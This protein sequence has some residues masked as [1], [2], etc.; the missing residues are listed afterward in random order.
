[1]VKTVLYRLH[2][3][4]GL[5]AGLVLAIVG[6][7]GAMLSFEEEIV[8]ALNRD[9]LRA[10]PTANRTALPPPQL[11]AAL[12]ATHP[13]RK[14]ANLTVFADA[15]LTPRVTFTA[16]RNPQG[17]TARNRRGET[18]HL[19]PYTGELLGKPTL[20][21]Q[22][23]LRLIEQLH[24][25]L[26]AG[27]PG[28]LIVGACTLALIAMCVSGLYLRWPRSG[29]GNWRRWLLIDN[30]LRGRAFLWQLHAVLG[31]WVLLAYL[32]S[33]LSGLYFSTYTW[34]RTGLIGMVGATPPSREA[35]RLP[36]A[37]PTDSAPLD[38]SALW[39]TFEQ[40]SG[41][42]SM[43]VL[44]LPQTPAHAAE[45]R[46]LATDAPHER[47]FSRMTFY[48]DGKL[49]RRERHQERSAGNRLIAAIFPLHSGSYFG[50]GGRIAMML[51]SL[52]MPVFAVSG[53]LLYLRRRRARV[54]GK[55][56]AAA[57]APLRSPA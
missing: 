57:G 19:N 54:T 48:P 41:G 11:L 6:L 45:V 34:Y 18:R 12:A 28:R 52:A 50:V 13:D 53:W 10:Q 22:E 46:Y 23:T 8:G 37:K 40:T 36:A 55:D 9:A 25:N 43:A 38:G 17:T 49:L 4:A 33:A 24:R 51:A 14:V 42:Y 35:P 32:L 30:R 15:K 21:G 3:F 56:S 31:T 7:S 16:P 29:A 39:A 5:T 44:T 1:M 20:R 27:P 26:T 2:W 47:A